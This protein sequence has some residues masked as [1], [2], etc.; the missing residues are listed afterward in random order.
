MDKIVDNYQPGDEHTKKPKFDLAKFL[1]KFIEKN[2]NEIL[3]EN[4]PNNS[5]NPKHGEATNNSR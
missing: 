4:N 5:L 2:K 3:N 1:T